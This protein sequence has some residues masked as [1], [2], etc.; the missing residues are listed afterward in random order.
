MSTTSKA[1]AYKQYIGIDPTYQLGHKSCSKELYD[2]ID[3]R[4][5]E[6]LDADVCQEY[7]EIVKEG[8]DNGLI[9]NYDARD[10]ELRMQ[11]KEWKQVNKTIR[12]NEARNNMATNS[13]P[14]SD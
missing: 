13:N 1:S 5:K 2:M 4:A 10:I 3:R 11:S 6:I 8:K 12:E 14:D 7:K 9:R